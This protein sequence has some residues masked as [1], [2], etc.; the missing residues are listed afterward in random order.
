[1]IFFIFFYFCGLFLPSWIRIQLGS[2]SATLLALLSRDPQPIHCMLFFLQ[3]LPPDVYT[4]LK[5]HLAWVKSEM[6]SWVTEDQQG[7]GLYADY[8][9]S[10]ITGRRMMSLE[11]R[12]QDPPDFAESCAVFPPI[13]PGPFLRSSVFFLVFPMHFFS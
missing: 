9:F 7:R 11:L 6:K 8:L 10:A 12:I 2:G 3:V 5:T 1:M 4:R 13:I